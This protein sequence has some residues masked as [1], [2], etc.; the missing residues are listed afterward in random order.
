[1]SKKYNEY[2]DY[3][4][5]QTA[6]VVPTS[7]TQNNTGSNNTGA[8][9]EQFDGTKLNKNKKRTKKVEPKPDEE[10]S[11]DLEKVVIIPENLKPTQ[12]RKFKRDNPNAITQEEFDRIK[13]KQQENKIEEND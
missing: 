4:N 12:L 9:T 11:I 2:L 7:L 10:L 1:M 6:R 13:L 3:V 8:K 5:K